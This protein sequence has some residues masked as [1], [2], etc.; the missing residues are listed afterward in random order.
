MYKRLYRNEHDK[1]IAGVGSGLADYLQL[2]VTIVR[3]LLVAMSLF[4]PGSG[5]ILYFVL[6]FVAPVKNDFNSRFS[7]FNP[8][9][10]ANP[11]TQDPMS[12]PNQPWVKAT[13][14]NAFNQQAGT[15]D[16]NDFSNFKANR[17]YEQKSRVIIGSVLISVGVYALLKKLAIIPYWFNFYKLWPLIIIALGIG[18]ILNRKRKKE[19]NDFIKSNPESTQATTDNSH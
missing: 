2:D 6:W 17:N 9:F 7:S 18:L 14:P 19:W 3:V 8:N 15:F 11:F 5:V 12:P 10:D 4:V 16:M 1:I 13:D